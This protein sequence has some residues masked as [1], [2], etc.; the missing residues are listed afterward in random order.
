MILLLHLSVGQKYRIYNSSIITPTCGNSIKLKIRKNYRKNVINLTVQWYKNTN[1]LDCKINRTKPVSFIG[2][3]LERKERKSP[4]SS[5]RKVKNIKIYFS[6]G[7]HNYLL[8]GV[9]KKQTNGKTNGLKSKKRKK[10]KKVVWQKKYKRKLIDQQNNNIARAKNNDCDDFSFDKQKRKGSKE[11]FISST[12]TLI[13]W[14]TS[15]RNQ[16]EA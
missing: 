5:L 10:E 6:L 14:I 9:S 15:L 11:T 12:Y 2:L 8:K 4:G 7:E 3:S 16:A 13:V 1:V